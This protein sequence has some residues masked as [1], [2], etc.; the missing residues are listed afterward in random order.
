MPTQAGAGD[1]LAVLV[2]QLDGAVVADV[3]IAVI[4]LEC[5]RLQR[6]HD[7]AAETAVDS[8]QPAACRHEPRPRGAADDRLA[9]V[10]AVR[11]GAVPAE[12]FVIGKV[13]GCGRKWVGVVRDH[14]AGIDDEQGAGVGKF[15]ELLLQQGVHLGVAAGAQRRYPHPRVGEVE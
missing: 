10:K 11:P 8:R 3:E 7:H 14:A 1:Q 2:Q 12:V 9:E 4:G 13:P 15:G 5:A 6:H